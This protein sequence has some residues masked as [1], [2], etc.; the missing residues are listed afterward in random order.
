MGRKRVVGPDGI[1]IEVSRCLGERGVVWLTT[2]FN[3][4]GGSNRMLVEWR[5]STIMPLYK[6]KGDIQDC[7]NYRGIKLMSHTMKLWERIIEQRLRRTVKISENQFGF[8]PRRPTMV[9]IH[10]IRKLMENYQDKRKDLHMVFI[11]LEKAYNKVP[12]EILW[13]ELSRKRIQ[14][15]YIDTIKDMYKGV[16][17][18]VRTNV[19]G[20]EGKLELWRQT[21]ESRGNR[22]SR[23]KTEYMECKFIGVQDR[24]T[25]E[26]ILDGKIVQGSEMFRY[27]GSIIQKNGELDGNVAHRIKAGESDLGILGNCLRE[28]DKLFNVVSCPENLRVNSVVYHIR[29]EV[30]LWWQRSENDLSS[31]PK[32]GWESF[33]TSLR[34]KFYPPYLKKDKP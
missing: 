22:L 10:L 31:L 29:N 14:M 26:I 19:E 8:M 33:K 11:D 1:P 16:S 6:N 25:G 20:V 4:I 7:S 23:N 30:D 24:E 21:F 17:T 28:F 27:L 13:W 32:F 9:A 3:K 12:R 34:N 18:S 15:K 5:K 2:L